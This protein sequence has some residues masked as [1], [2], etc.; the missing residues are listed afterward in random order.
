[1][2]RETFFLSLFVIW[3]ISNF[4]YKG[5]WF[6]ITKFYQKADR[7]IHF[8]NHMISPDIFPSE[9]T[10]KNPGEQGNE[11]QIPKSIP[12]YEDKYLTDIRKMNKEFTWNDEEEQIKANKYQEYKKQIEFNY[13]QKVETV[14]KALFELEEKIKE[15]HAY[16]EEYCIYGEDTSDEPGASDDDADKVINDEYGETKEVKIK[17]LTDEKNKLNDQLSNLQEQIKTPDYQREI[18][19]RAD[20]LATEFMTDKIL[21]KLKNCYIMETT[22]LGNVLMI[23]DIEKNTFVYYSDNTIPYRYLEPV[24]RKYV[25]IYNCRPIF[26]DMEEELKLAEE[27]WEKDRVEKEQKEEEE[28][29]RAEELKMKNEPPES[30]KNV[31]A[32]FKS[33]NK[34]TTS[35]K[36][37]AA[38]PKNSI[39]NKNLTKEQENEKVLLK[40]R[41]NRYRYEG[42]MSNFSFLKKVKRNVVDKKYAMTFSDFKRMRIV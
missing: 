28:K 40:D 6:F 11:E 41:A 37:M 1:M 13:Q 36:S 9:E 17:I 5:L 12:K 34:D 10:S 32:K 18:I 20:T 15:A 19:K 39:P 25:K 22:P 2:N 24:A 27:K 30:K 35:S 21:D 29:R 4:G 16:D 8:C 7:F 14:K 23:Y 38:P 31:F 42:K 33:Y 26:V 3:Y